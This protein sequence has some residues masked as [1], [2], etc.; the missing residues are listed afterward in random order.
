[1]KLAD[2]YSSNFTK[3]Y[4]CAIVL[5]GHYFMLQLLLAVINSNLN[6]I[7]N[8]ENFNEMKQQ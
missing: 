6:K 5:I 1:M 8:L 4:F 7:L 3:A 2:G